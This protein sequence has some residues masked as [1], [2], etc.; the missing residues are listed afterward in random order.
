MNRLKENAAIKAALQRPPDEEEKSR[1]AG[2]VAAT[3]RQHPPSLSM[4]KRVRQDDAGEGGGG[5]GAGAGAAGRADEPF[6]WANPAHITAYMQ[7]TWGR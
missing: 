1:I 2:E 5:A 7:G 6:N 4:A 3:V